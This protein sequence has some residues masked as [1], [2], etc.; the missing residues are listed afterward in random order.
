MAGEQESL[1]T[2]RRDI[3]QTRRRLDTWDR[4][5]FLIF[6]AV[7]MTAIIAGSDDLGFLSFWDV[8]VEFFTS[9]TG[10][11]LGTIFLLEV[12]RQIHY[13]FSERSAAYNSFWQDSIFGGIQRWTESHFKPWT[14]FR[15]G[16]ANR[17]GAVCCRRPACQ[18]SLQTWHWQDA[19]R[20]FRCTR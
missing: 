2:R 5:K 9:T 3:R 7:V 14:R 18:S 4:I 1:N 19:M 12:L 10:K 17:A 6:L 8:V 20:C 11:V 16:R 13:W 15:V